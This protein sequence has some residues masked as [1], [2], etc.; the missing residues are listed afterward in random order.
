MLVTSIVPPTV[1]APATS[2]V[3]LRSAAPFTLRVESN[4][5]DAFTNIPA[6]VEVGVN[7]LVNRVSH[8]PGAPPAPPH[9]PPKSANVLFAPHCTQFPEDPV[10]P[11]IIE[12]LELT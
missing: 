4:V 11:E 10:P 1:V 8:A 2:R 12:P 9:A 5:E 6:V 7:A 3:E